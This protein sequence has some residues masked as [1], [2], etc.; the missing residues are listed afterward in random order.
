ME[1]QIHDGYVS[2]YYGQ[3]CF[4]DVD[5]KYVV[6]GHSQIYKFRIYD[7]QGQ[8]VL[9]VKDD[10]RKMGRFNRN[11]MSLII[12][13]RFTPQPGDSSLRKSILTQLNRDKKKLKKILNDIE[14]HKNIIAD[15]KITGSR[16][17]VYPVPVDI[18][19]KERCP[20]EIYDIDGRKR[21]KGF[22]KRK[23]ALLSEPYAFFYKNN[24]NDEPQIVKYKII[25]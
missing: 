14:Q 2:E 23:P 21:V 17:Y 15:I 19:D 8:L 9:E 25:E 20:V 13:N 5:K 1:K 7:E 6:F 24:D 12:E 11:E 10:K 3:N 4:I 22:F 16:I 18:T